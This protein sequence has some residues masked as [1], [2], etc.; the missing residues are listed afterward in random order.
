[1]HCAGHQFDLNQSIEVFVIIYNVSS[2]ILQS[3]KNSFPDGEESDSRQM[4]LGVLGEG[5][6]QDEYDDVAGVDSR[7]VDS[8]ESAEYFQVDQRFVREAVHDQHVSDVKSSV[9]QVA[10][11]W[12]GD[13]CNCSCIDNCNPTIFY[14]INEKYKKNL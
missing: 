6:S 13:V 14:I 11:K 7:D 12:Q 2:R 3:F 5:Q 9:V 10:K 4:Y 1:M 8:Q